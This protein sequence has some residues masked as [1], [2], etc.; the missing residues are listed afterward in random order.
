MKRLK[1]KKIHEIKLNKKDIDNLSGIGFWI[2]GLVKDGRKIYVSEV[3]FKEKKDKTEWLF[4]D[5]VRF[6]DRIRYF[7][8]INKAIKSQEKVMK[9]FEWD[10]KKR[11]LVIVK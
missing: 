9:Y 10:K 7:F 1:D 6:K 5:P 4:S 3:Y 11:K 8:K 2:Y